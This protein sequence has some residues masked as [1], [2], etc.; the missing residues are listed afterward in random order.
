V[1][2]WLF[3]AD[4][5]SLGTVALSSWFAWLMLGFILA[6]EVAIREARRSGEQPRAVLRISVAAIAAGLVGC[7]LGHFV[8]VAPAEVLARPAAIFEF[9]EGGMVFFPGLLAG[10]ATVA[11]WARRSG[12]S[13]LR[14][15]DMLAPAV[16]IGHAAGRVGCLSAGCCFGRP[17]DWG[18][19]IEW[20]WA[21]VF[22]EGQVP[23]AL[24]G[25]P[26][27]PTQAYAALDAVGLFLL[28]T[29]LRGRQRFSGQVAGA[30]LLGHGTLRAWEELFRLD[31]E[32]GFFLESLI[33]QRVS[34]SQGIAAA[35]AAW[36]AAIL[37][38][39]WRRDTVREGGGRHVS[40][41]PT[42]P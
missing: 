13:F 8:F 12:R 28:L 25:V 19:G 11:I 32:R 21:V 38:R 22:L 7:R 2:T 31:V 26:L 18:T 40:D 1:R 41:P 15:A 42:G 10:I 37:L 9:W 39:G 36:G 27:H 6:M 24:R 35:L 3:Q 33:G 29:W 16:M 4:L 23:T 20:P 17:I 5:P 14:V 34:T 30:M